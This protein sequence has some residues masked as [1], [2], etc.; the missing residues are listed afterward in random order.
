MRSIILLVASITCL[1]AFADI[2]QWTDETGHMQISDHQPARGVNFKV[3]KH[4]GTQASTSPAPSIG[5]AP[6]A[7]PADTVD[8]KKQQEEQARQV[9][10][11]AAKAAQLAADCHELIRK[12]ATLN[13]GHRV[14]NTDDQGQTS[15]LSDDQINQ[16]RV[17]VDQQLADKGCG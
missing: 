7:K 15:Y 3:I 1:P 14:L 17:E 8:P 5:V 11:Q 4:S 16:Q 9:Q 12:K 6:V 2:Y 13:S 10:A